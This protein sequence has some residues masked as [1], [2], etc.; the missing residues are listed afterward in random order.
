MSAEKATIQNL[1][2]VDL[3]VLEPGEYVEIHDPKGA[4]YQLEACEDGFFLSS[5][6][7][8]LGKVKGLGGELDI[9]SELSLRPFIEKTIQVS[10]IRG[11]LKNRVEDTTPVDQ[12]ERPNG[13]LEWKL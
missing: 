1:D 2:H 8:M 3:S 10:V 12:R 9:G 13:Q 5:G 7:Q 11:L 6:S 4:L